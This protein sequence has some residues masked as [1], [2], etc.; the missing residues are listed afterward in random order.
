VED[1]KPRCGDRGNPNGKSKEGKFC[2]CRQN[3]AIKINLEKEPNYMNNESCKITKIPEVKNPIV[4]RKR[5]GS[6][7]YEVRSYFNPEAEESIEEKILRILKN[8]LTS[9]KNRG[10]MRM[11]QTVRLPERS[12]A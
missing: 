2:K 3:Y 4:T 7:T 10:I 6:T 12:S 9:G 11:S 5:I 1:Y 8:D